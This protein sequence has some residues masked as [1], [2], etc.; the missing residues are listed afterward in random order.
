MFVTSESG[1]FADEYGVGV[2]G[3]LSRRPTRR[4]LLL[5]HRVPYPPDRGDRIRSYH[6]LKLLSRHFD[7]ALACTTQEPVAAEHRHVLSQLTSRLAIR[8]LNPILSKARGAAA[9][10]T[11]QPITPSLFYD[12]LLARQIVRWHEDKPFDAVLT[13]CTGML[14]YGRLLTHPAYRSARF[15]GARPINVL[16][17]VDVD[18]MKWA[19]YAKHTAG[20]MKWVY[21]TEATRLARVEAGLQDRFDAITVISGARGTGLPH[22]AP[23]PPRP[24][25]R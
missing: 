11:G 14:R 1:R 8:G 20:P 25:G 18:S 6:L 13:F 16:D 12:P 4:V 19:A 10:A 5:T 21:R 17:L 23:R 15:A 9:L 7:V 22:A 2:L 24:G 3:T